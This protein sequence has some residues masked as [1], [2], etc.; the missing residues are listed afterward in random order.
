MMLAR[1]LAGML[2][3]GQEL[4]EEKILD[5]LA[6]REKLYQQMSTHADRLV[7]RK[8]V[9]YPP[10][11]MKA[12][13]G[14]R[15]EKSGEDAVAVYYRSYLPVGENLEAYGLLILPKK[16]V[17]KR[18]PLVI[19]MHGG[20]GSPEMAT[21]AGGANYK[22]QVRGAVAEGYAVYAPHSVM[23]PFRDRDAGT[24]I[25]ADVRRVL[26]E[27]FREAGTSLAA[28]EVYK[29]S[30]ALDELLKRPDVDAKRVA[31]IGLSYGGFYSLYAGALEPRIGVVVA[32]CSFLDEPEERHGKTE[33]RL[34]ELAPAEVAALIAPRP[35]MVQSG[36]QDKLMPIEVSRKAAARTAFVYKKVQSE[37][38]FVFSEF[39]GGHEFS[40]AAVWAFL[41]KWL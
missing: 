32:S 6:L 41:K 18:M 38:R 3:F 17:A 19:S 20:G 16:P 1:A 8:R 35:L 14:M 22:D 9:G 7:L 33:G 15:L 4:Y 5:T 30:L 40:G 12:S 26:D 37:D 27:R 31:M 2:L 28:V 25:P 23:Y 34:V 10:P 39:E 29:V 11:Q 24:T 13:G 36:K 21:F